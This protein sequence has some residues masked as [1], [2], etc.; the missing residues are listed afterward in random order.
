MIYLLAS[1]N[2]LRPS[3][4]YMRQYINHQSMVQI[5]VR[6]LVGAKP[7]YEPMLEYC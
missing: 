1:V 3:E 4:A 6:R 2:S 5:T 7:L